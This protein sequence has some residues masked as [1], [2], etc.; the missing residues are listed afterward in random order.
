MSVY[1]ETRYTKSLRK[2]IG[3]NAGKMVKE[4]CVYITKSLTD[5]HIHL[6][7]THKARVCRCDTD[8]PF[9]LG[10]WTEVVYDGIKGKFS[11]AFNADG[12]PKE[13]VA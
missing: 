4:P 13:K 11:P 10:C 1:F 9:P 12:T 2:R 8:I 6:A 5:L 7:D 3:P